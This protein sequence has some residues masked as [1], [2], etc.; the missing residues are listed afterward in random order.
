MCKVNNKMPENPVIHGIAIKT[1]NLI[2]KVKA[3]YLFI[4]INEQILKLFYDNC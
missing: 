2:Y 1:L 3:W 4:I